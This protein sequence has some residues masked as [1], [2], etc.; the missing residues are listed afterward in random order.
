MIRRKTKLQHK[1]IEWHISSYVPAIAP[2]NEDV[3][4]RRMEKVEIVC[5]SYVCP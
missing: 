5:H 3:N 2:S 4:D 1:R